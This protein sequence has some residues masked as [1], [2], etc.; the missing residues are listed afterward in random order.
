MNTGM[1]IKFL[2]LFSG[3]IMLSFNMTA[4]GFT[5][6]QCI[7]YAYRNNGNIIN[8]GYDIDIA[9][10]EVDEQRGAALPQV[11]ASGSA[12]DNL[13][14]GTTILPGEMLGQEGKTIAV[15]MGTKYNYS[16]G[17]QLSQ[18]L[19]DPAL[20]LSLKAARL[21]EDQSEQSLRQTTE[22]VVYNISALY[23]RT[24]VIEKQTK[25]LQAT[26]NSSKALL[27]SSELKL[28]NGMASQLDV[29]KMRVS[30]NNT[31][32][33]L[34]Q[35]ELSYK[36]SLNNLKYYMG[37][38]VDS[39]IVLADS[40]SMTDLQPELV[41]TEDFSIENRADYQ[42]QKISLQ[43]GELDEKRNKSGYLPSLSLNAYLGYSAMRN[44]FDFTNNWDWYQSSYIGLSLKIPVFD[45]LQRNARVKQSKLNIEKSNVSISQYKESIK[46]ELIN[47]EIGYSNALDNIRSEKANLD[48]A[49]HVFKNTQLQYQQGTCSTL[50]LVQAET[51][52]RE[53]LNNYYDKLLNLYIARITL[54]KSKGTLTNYI[55]TL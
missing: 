45:G 55:N 6:K 27:E 28:A 8:A 44:E 49:E 33:M 12:I 24:M 25:S 18:K 31:E 48:L 9:Q 38:P 1:K 23:Y 50:D 35:S 7:D 19:F 3:L 32:T 41:N 52:Y 2:L 15:K 4:Q 34:N 39:M 13:V 42:L 5:L 47:S 53:S 40:V 26:Y 10:R 54:E 43:A 29:D 22:N 30:C 36:L 16:G 20:G 11:D 14:L 37:M 17:V 21:S 51:S 46:V